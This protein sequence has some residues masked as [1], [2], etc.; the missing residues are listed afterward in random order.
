MAALPSDR[1]R[2]VILEDDHAVRRSMQ[3]LLQANGFDVKAYAS[4]DALLADP[5][6]FSAACIVVDYRLEGWDGLAVLARL[7][8]HGWNGPA[9]LVT[10]FGSSALAAQ[11][12]AAGFSEVIEKPCKER[13]LVNAVA[14]HVQVV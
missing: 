4:A 11:A 3:L 8:R 14:R 7:K 2:I 12:E 6:T 1:P 13:V 9:I 10:A 5:E